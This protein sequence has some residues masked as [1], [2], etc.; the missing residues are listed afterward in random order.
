M[1]RTSWRSQV[2]D[3]THAVTIALERGILHLD[4]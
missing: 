3:C 1:R 4:F 2:L